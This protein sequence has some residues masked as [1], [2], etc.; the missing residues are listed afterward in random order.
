MAARSLL[1]ALNMLG[2]G[3]GSRRALGSLDTLRVDVNGSP[4][5]LQGFN[6][7]LTGLVEDASKLASRVLSEGGVHLRGC[8]DGGLPPMPVISR[9]RLPAGRGLLAYVTQ[10]FE[11][12][13][14][15]HV[16][17]NFFVRAE[18]CRVLY[19][20]PECQDKLRAGLK[21]WVLGLPRAQKKLGTGYFIESRGV[22]RRASPIIASCHRDRNLWGGGCVVTMIASADWPSTLSWTGTG[23]RTIN[24]DEA[25]IVDALDTALGELKDYLSRLGYNFNRVWP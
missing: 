25:G 9:R 18:R 1:A 23:K 22:D 15:F 11:T 16:V 12:R 24:V 21:A 17:H 7:L 3:K 6:R 4:M 5:L 19:G 2:V 20:D 13:A 10:V 14:P 8:S